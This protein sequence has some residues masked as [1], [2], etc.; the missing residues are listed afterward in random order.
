MG[1]QNISGQPMLIYSSELPPAQ[2]WRLV[3]SL[4]G[5]HKK[6]IAWSCWR[7][8]FWC[9]CLTV[10][11]VGKAPRGKVINLI[12]TGREC[13]VNYQKT[14]GWASPWYWSNFSPNKIWQ[15]LFRVCRAT[16][17]S[18]WKKKNP[19]A[20]AWRTSYLPPGMIWHKV[21]FN[22]GIRGGESR[23]W[24]EI[25]ALLLIG[26]PGPKAWMHVCQALPAPKT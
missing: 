5:L 20:K 10:L 21:F 1:F 25:H 3:I 16:W 15:S 24:A 12:T 18:N 19:D 7:S 26:S 17:W 11:T 13:L 8:P 22:V 6:K 2:I 23:A 9:A 4:C 14:R